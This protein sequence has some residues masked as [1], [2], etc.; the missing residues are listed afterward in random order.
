MSVRPALFGMLAEFR[1]ALL[2][3][4]EAARR[5]HSAANVVLRSG[6]PVARSG[7]TFQYQFKVN[8]L[9]QLPDDV[10]A[11]LVIQGRPHVDAT[12]ITVAGLVVTLAV[13]EDLGPFIAKA[14]LQAGLAQLLLKLVERIEALAHVPNPAGERAFGRSPV[15]GE[16]AR[17]VPP[18]ENPR[19]DAAVAS[20]LGR[21]TTFIWGPPGTGKTTTIGTFGAQMWRRKRSVL[22]VSHTNVAIDHAILKVAEALGGEA[23]LAD[24][25]VIRVGEPRLRALNTRPQLLARTYVEDLSKELTERRD[26]LLSSRDGAAARLDGLEQLLDRTQWVAA[27]AADL[28]ELRRSAEEISLSAQQQQEARRRLDEDGSRAEEWHR[29]LREATELMTVEAELETLS[30]KASDSL[31]RGSVLRNALVASDAALD[32]GERLLA[33]VRGTGRLTRM[34]SRLPD[35]VEQLAVVELLRAVRERSQAALDAALAEADAIGTQIGARTSALDS[36][37]ARTRVTPAEAA[38]EAERELEELTSRG[39]SHAL[40]EAEF[41][42]DQREQERAVRERWS[43]LQRM[44]LVRGDLGEQHPG[45]DSLVAVH[46][47]VAASLGDADSAA[48]SQ[49]VAQV[50]SE[51]EATEGLLAD[52]DDELRRVE[53]LVIARATIVATTLTR[54]Y[55]RPAIFN[56]SYDTVLLDEASMAPMPALW[57]AAALA[58]RNV[59]IVGDFKQLPPICLSD[60]PIAIKWL[61]R[62]IF[63]EAGVSPAYEHG[64]PPPFF[65]ALTR[66][67]RMLPA[68]SAIP[69]ALVYGGMLEDGAGAGE[70]A[71]PP[72]WWDDAVLSSAGVALVDT[73]PAE[74]WV[75]SAGGDGRASS[76]L[77]LMSALLVTAIAAAALREPRPDFDPAVGPRV[78][79]ISPYRPHARFIGRLLQQLEIDGEVIAGTA[80]SF[81]GS[82]APVVILDLV[83]DD[84]H[85]RVG[86]FFDDEGKQTTMRLFNVAV[87]RAKSRLI[88]VGDF[89]YAMQLTKPT[90]FMHGFVDYLLKHY[91]R[92]DAR[93]LGKIGLA[94]RLEGT[95]LEVLEDDLAVRLIEDVRHARERVVLYAPE[96]SSATLALL[97]PELRDAITRKVDVYVLAPPLFERGVRLRP[98]YDTSEERLRRVGVHVI[99]KPKMHE[100]VALFDHDLVYVSSQSPLADAEEPQLTFRLCGDGINAEFF[101]MLQLE[102]VLTLVAAGQARCPICEQE[103]L[104]AEG[105]EG[106]YWRC[107]DPE[108]HTRSLNAPAPRDGRITCASPDCGAAV[109]YGVWG[110]RPHWRCVDNRRHRQP[111]APS[112]LKLPKMCQLVPVAERAGL[113]SRLDEYR[114]HRQQS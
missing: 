15:A 25:S 111:I 24:G 97:E 19:Q 103:L 56:R 32:N 106:L 73:G 41:A 105:R 109:E 20:C 84:P 27:A 104:P 102:P 110:D 39:L 22:V 46:E 64:E 81:Q 72:S 70:D 59:V 49:S 21:D 26:E 12:I 44:N 16:P 3:E 91:D 87:T 8:N 55:L 51:I 52:V 79:I 43:A 31:A 11:E 2:A 30:P 60:D 107:V 34:W 4:Y 93:V 85:W 113:E 114:R 45:L 58:E 14:N 61:G 13:S 18:G 95:V 86:V 10:P 1:D 29:T 33:R 80:H 66:Q 17:D 98:F 108:C 62:D 35:P 37:R 57:A 40:K 99:H 47:A 71:G 9:V 23:E 5:A 69:N 101:K 65:V 94:P 28:A 100:K 63:E 76:R 90:A 53:E 50:R 112:H 82:E 7:R 89:K 88:I 48:L 67:H 36:F 38:R 92:T 78:L 74:A 96:M 75:T 6:R 77:N 42:R 68:I 83:N 54:A